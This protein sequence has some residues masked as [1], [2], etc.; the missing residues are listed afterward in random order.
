MKVR[1]KRLVALLSRALST[2]EVI[3]NSEEEGVTLRLFSSNKQFWAE[4]CAGFR[5]GQEVRILREAG[6][7]GETAII[8]KVVSPEEIFVLLDH[9]SDRGKPSMR[10]YANYELEAVERT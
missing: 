4:F 10:V 7:Q 5:K 6:L 2:S 9:W 1:T 8:Y 3:G